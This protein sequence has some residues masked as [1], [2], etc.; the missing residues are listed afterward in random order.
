ML[1]NVNQTAPAYHSKT[2]VEDAKKR[3]ADIENW[4][5]NFL[6]SDE[7]ISWITQFNALVPAHDKLS[8]LK[9]VDFILWQTR[10]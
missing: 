9:K 7:G 2:K 4:Y 3:Y 1:R 10:D 6:P 8:D 5:Q